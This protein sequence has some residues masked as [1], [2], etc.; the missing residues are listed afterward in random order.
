[1][2][3]STRAT[4]TESSTMNARSSFTGGYTGTGR[5]G[6]RSTAFARIGVQLELG[7]DHAR[8][9]E[10]EAV[11]HGRVQFADPADRGAVDEHPGR[12]SRPQRVVL[13]GLEAQ[14]RDGERVGQFLDDALDVEEVHR[15]AVGRLPAPGRSRGPDIRIARRTR[16]VRQGLAP[17]GQEDLADLE[18]RQPVG[19][20]AVRGRDFEI[21]ASSVRRMT[22]RSTT[23]GFASRT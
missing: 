4:G 5:V 17:A 11:R 22:T 9:L 1:M 21:P 19:V 6:F 14:P 2:T 13:A 23:M 18:A 16:L 8:A 15:R 7:H 10:I 3:S 12:S 20:A